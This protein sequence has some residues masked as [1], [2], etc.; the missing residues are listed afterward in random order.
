MSFLQKNNRVGLLV[1]FLGKMSDKLE[2][3]CVCVVF[4]FQ[5][6]NNN[7]NNKKK[8]VGMKFYGGR[9]FFIRNSTVHPGDQINFSGLSSKS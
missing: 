9:S 2:T 6:N 5:G 4:P 8:H 3:L 1:D 7:N